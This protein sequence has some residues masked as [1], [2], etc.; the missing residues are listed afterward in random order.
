M[1]PRTAMTYRDPSAA[2]PPISPLYLRASVGAVDTLA[3]LAIA[4]R[5]PLKK[6]QGALT[7]APHAQAEQPLALIDDTV[8]GSGKSGMLLTDRAAYFSD[9][10]ARVPVEAIVQAPSFPQGMTQQGALYTSLGT[11]AL[12]KLLDESTLAMNR[13]LRAVAFFNRGADRLSYAL[14]PVLGPVGEL[15]AQVL[16]HEHIPLVPMVPAKAVHAASN[17]LGAW[18]DADGGEELLAFFDETGSGAGDRFLAL[19]DRR[20]LSRVG[21]PFEV[22]YGAILD[23]S[24]KSGMLTHTISIQ[25]AQGT[26]KH[27]TIANTEAAR[28]VT[29]FLQHL[30]AIP[31]EQRRAWPGPA[32]TEDDPAGALAA[33]RS[34]PQPDVRVAALL[35]LVYASVTRGAMPVDAG[36]D[37]TLRV[38]RL[39][40]TL[41]G[42][43]GTTQGYSRTALNAGDFESVLSTVF[44]PPAAQRMIDASTGMLEYDM[45]RAGS[46]AGT[47]ASNV[48]GL[49][50]LAVV[51]V[52]WMSS[53]SGG[54]QT[55]FVRLTDAPGGAAF[56]LTDVSQKPLGLDN[57]KLS[58]GLLDAVT[59]LSAVMLLRRTLLGWNV[60]S[61]T[62]VQEPPGSLDARARALVPAIDTAPFLS[63]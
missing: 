15:A 60:P 3:G 35:E 18:L 49:T 9:S 54:T 25:T 17:T 58:G 31:P 10:R 24:F 1:V 38:L 7:Y 20:V 30:R 26:R 45:R 27:E 29:D 42:G 57:A 28:K 5:I 34:L 14:Q 19:T 44:G 59:Q 50:L 46:A 56:M 61:R 55:V 43:H 6:L 23:A 11:L 16:E 8:L 12:P 2:R 53:G 52:G 39:Q 36:R 47:I 51:G 32:P 22:P 40:R 4:P 21:D 33:L 63:E 62:L 37:M 48:I 13:V 41:R